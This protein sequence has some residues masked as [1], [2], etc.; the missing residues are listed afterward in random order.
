MIIVEDSR[1]Q[2]G[3]HENKH[4]WWSDNGHHL[5]RSKLP[6]GDYALPPKVAIDTKM[7]MGEIAN[8]IGGTRKEHE[9]FRREL[10]L[11][12]EC[13]STLYI[14]VENTDGIRRLSD[15]QNWYNPRL[16]QNPKSITGLRL[17]KAMDTMQQKYG[18]TFLFCR[19][20]ESAHVI[21]T[22]LERED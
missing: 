8:N 15:V 3:K 4:K 13:G 20:E 16:K 17:C 12:K 11:A 2:E 1:Q 5:I 7:S 19:P 18:V 22:I 6:Y 9:R 21:T 14:L 10:Q